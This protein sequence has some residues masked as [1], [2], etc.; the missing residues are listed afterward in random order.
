MKFNNLIFT[1]IFKD[2][3]IYKL[4]TV[5]NNSQNRQLII[6]FDCE[7]PLYTK[8]SSSQKDLWIFPFKK[9]EMEKHGD[10]TLRKANRMLVFVPRNACLC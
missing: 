7:I 3:L 1:I 4:N 8:V 10:T 6:H 9:I 5:F 2:V